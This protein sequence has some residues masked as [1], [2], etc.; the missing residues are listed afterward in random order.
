MKSLGRMGPGLWNA[1]K[2][3]ACDVLFHALLEELALQ[4]M[5][6]LSMEERPTLFT[7]KTEAE[8]E[9]PERLNSILR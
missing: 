9:A 5:G 1:I 6:G 2:D 3:L 7:N 8:M 4:F